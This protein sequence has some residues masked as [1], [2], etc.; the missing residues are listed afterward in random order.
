[1]TTEEIETL[2]TMRGRAMRRGDE[3]TADRLE[4]L[5]ADSGVNLADNDSGTRWFL[6]SWPNK[7]EC[8][9]SDTG[10]VGHV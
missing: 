2:V 5:L 4:R 8:L 9:I 10:D 7:N 6:V 3:L 1:V